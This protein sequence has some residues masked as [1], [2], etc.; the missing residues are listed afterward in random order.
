MVSHPPLSILF[1]AEADATALAALRSYLRS[2]PHVQATV[3]S[4][5]PGDVSDVDVVVTTGTDAVA[6]DLHRLIDF[7]NRGG[8]W[9]HLAPASLD[10]LPDIF[11]AQPTALGPATELRRQQLPRPV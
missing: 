9:L 1:V 10:R 2:I 6:G 5:L 11:G 8:G 3:L 7:V 4:R